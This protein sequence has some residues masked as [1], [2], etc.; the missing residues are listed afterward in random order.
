MTNTTPSAPAKYGLLRTSLWHRQDLAQ[1]W[2]LVANLAG[3][4]S[5]NP[6][7]QADQIALG[8]ASG[9]RGLPEQ[10]ALGDSGILGGIELRTPV[11]DMNSDWK[12]RPS[13]F[14]Q[15]GKTFDQVSNTES[16][17]TTA[18]IGIQIGHDDSLRASFH[19]GW[20]LDQGGAEIH[21][22]LTWKF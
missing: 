22:Q 21:S 15:S 6:V 2:D 19:S 13:L 11:I 4:W 12:L 14:L 20:R 18:G 10:F 17:A 5:G 7:L 9:L 16:S 3:Q 1:G 8:G